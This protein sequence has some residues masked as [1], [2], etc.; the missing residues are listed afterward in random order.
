[1]VRTLG[2]RVR[3]LRVRRGL[4][5][6]GLARELV[7]PSYVSLI[8][9]GKRLPEREILQAFAERLGT[10]PEYLETGVDAVT[11][12]EE[13]LALRY[14][15]LALANGQI[16]EALQRY[17]Q[18][19][20]TSLL[21]R[22]AAQWGIARALE[23]QGDLSGLETH[24]ITRRGVIRRENRTIMAEEGHAGIVHW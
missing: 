13:L 17:E 14:A 18:L 20:R 1:M 2:D 5:Q 23:A 8:E 12:R 15:D 9:S 16:Q 6:S 7:S 22:H 24:R 10:T 3:D 11:A 19:A 21:S 4:S